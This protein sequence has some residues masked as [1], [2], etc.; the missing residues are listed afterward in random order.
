M[1]SVSDNRSTGN[2][3]YQLQDAPTSNEY[4]IMAVGRLK[5]KQSR[6]EGGRN[7][8]LD[9]LAPTFGIT[10]CV[11]AISQSVPVGAWDDV[12]VN[13]RDDLAG[14]RPVVM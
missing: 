2:P 3:T 4:P 8:L 11:P 13:V 10:R 6:A 12:K 14:N 7:R 1:Q 9:L 5:V